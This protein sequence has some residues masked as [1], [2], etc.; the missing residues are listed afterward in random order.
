MFLTVIG[1]VK[2]A[3]GQGRRQRGTATLPKPQ[4]TIEVPVQR[5]AEFIPASFTATDDHEANPLNLEGAR[6]YKTGDDA[7]TLV[8]GNDE[9]QF[10]LEF[11]ASTLCAVAT[12]S[13]DMSTCNIDDLLGLS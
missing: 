3:Q 1:G 10:A 5:L 2:M 13:K 7:I 4:D 11:K 8:L 9:Q 6:W 12:R